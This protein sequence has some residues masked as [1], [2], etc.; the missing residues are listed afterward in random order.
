MSTYIV[1]GITSDNLGL[2]V[3]I[4][5]PETQ[6]ARKWYEKNSDQYRF[7]R[8]FSFERGVAYVVSNMRDWDQRRMDLKQR[9]FDEKNWNV[10]GRL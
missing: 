4:P 2:R 9:M 1:E 3:A 10:F 6:D 5:F 7:I 8:K